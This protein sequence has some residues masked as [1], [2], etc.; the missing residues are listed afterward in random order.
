MERYEIELL[1]RSVAMLPPGHS[2]GATS[3]E[4]AQDLFAELARSD[5]ENARYRELVG[6]LRRVLEVLDPGSHSG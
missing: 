1:R 6:K 3:R 4:Q 2:V 5:I